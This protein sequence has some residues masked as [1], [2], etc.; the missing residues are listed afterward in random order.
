MESFLLKLILGHRLEHKVHKD[1]TSTQRVPT[2]NEM[3]KLGQDD[4]PV[5]PKQL[6]KRPDVRATN[7]SQ[8]KSEPKEATK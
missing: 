4:T 3:P 6:G 8:P 7:A 5:V 2:M 1:N